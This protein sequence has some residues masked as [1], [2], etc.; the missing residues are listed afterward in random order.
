ME[1]IFSLL[2]FS[3]LPFWVLIIL[4]PR[5]RLTTRV[6]RMPGV[7]I[8]PLV[9]YTLF[10]I[11]NLAEFVMVLIRPELAEISRLLASETGTLLAWAHFLAFD[12]FVGRWIYLDS[13]DRAAPVW[14]ISPLL[15][16]T[17]VVGPVG[18]LLYLLFRFL[19]GVRNQ[20]QRSSEAG[21]R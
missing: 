21:G 14:I 2:T 7:T 9:A 15:A 8:L 10:L 16:A 17:L 18:L 20:V 11:P 13:Q 19:D 6:I 3:V 12:L 1:T 5:F 4:A